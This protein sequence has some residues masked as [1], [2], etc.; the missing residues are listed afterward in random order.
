MPD[1]NVWALAEP[2]Q[3]K[4]EGIKARSNLLRGGIAEGLAVPETGKIDED[5]TQL[6]KF[7]GIYQQDDRDLRAE[8]GRTR[9]ERIPG[10]QVTMAQWLAL[11]EIARERATAP[12]VSPRARRCSSTVS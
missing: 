1:N 10:G 8:R 9:M 6:T 11:H 3:S 12:S 7:H 5:D 4:N 2:N